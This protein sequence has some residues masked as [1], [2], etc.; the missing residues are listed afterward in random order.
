ME[1]H[2]QTKRRRDRLE[3]ISEILRSTLTGKVKTR[4]MYKANVNF[5]QFKE[6]MGYLMDAGL[7]M[8]IKNGKRTIY[9]TTDKGLLLLHKLKESELL[10]NEVNCGKTTETVIVKKGPAYFVKR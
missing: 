2:A 1:N 10:F 4:I 7:I 5:N 3:I 6:Y 9:K 8:R